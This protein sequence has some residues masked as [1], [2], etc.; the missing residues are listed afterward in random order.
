MGGVFSDAAGRSG[1]AD[2]TLVHA[3]IYCAGLC[4]AVRK[5]V[6]QHYPST[7]HGIGNQGVSWEAWTNLNRVSLHT[8]PTAS[9]GILSLGCAGT[10][11]QRGAACVQCLD[12]K[13]TKAYRGSC[14]IA[15]LAHH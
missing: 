1:P 11:E 2:M 13:G 6:F 9:R 8:V 3:P 5:P 14:P 15:A 4:P 12:I 10:V 7:L